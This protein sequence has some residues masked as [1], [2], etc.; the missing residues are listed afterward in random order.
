MIIL[1]CYKRELLSRLTCTL[2]GNNRHKLSSENC[3]NLLVQYLKQD[4]FNRDYFYVI[5]GKRKQKDDTETDDSSEDSDPKPRKGRKPVSK[6]D[7][8]KGNKKLLQKC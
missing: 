4:S 6:A 5:A 3:D 7:R 1:L 2:N 8:R